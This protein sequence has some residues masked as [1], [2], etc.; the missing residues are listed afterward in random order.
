MLGRTHFVCLAVAALVLGATAGCDDK[1]DAGAKGG[2]NVEARCELLGS[3][4]GDPVKADKLIGECK[5]AA[6]TQSAHGCAGQA[7]AA[8]DCYEQKLCARGDQVWGLDD[9]RV[10]ADRY[11]SCATEREA[12]AA[13]VGK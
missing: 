9:F 5:Q 10:L 13:C 3:R 1:K 2:V 6:A 7:I 11:K 12:L 8:Y 4:C